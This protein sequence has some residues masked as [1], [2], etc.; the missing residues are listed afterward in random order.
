MNKNAK[1][2]PEFKALIERY[3]AITLK[4]IKDCLKD[5]DYDMDAV[6]VRLTGFGFKHRCTLCAAAIQQKGEGESMCHVCV[7]GNSDERRRLS[8]ACTDDETY[9]AIDDAKHPGKLLKAY[10]ARAKYMRTLITE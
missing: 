6:R 5:T 9:S 4:E 1:N 8:L 2:L 10:R 7:Y 3:E